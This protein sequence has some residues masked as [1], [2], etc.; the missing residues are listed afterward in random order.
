M[1]RGWGPRGGRAPPEG[2]NPKRQ[3]IHPSI[4]KPD[5][6]SFRGWADRL[7]TSETLA[8]LERTIEAQ[9]PS[10]SVALV[11]SYHHEDTGEIISSW[12]RT[13]P[14]I[15]PPGWK[16][17]SAKSMVPADVIRSTVEQRVP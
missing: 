13:S 4:A 5:Y 15:P 12:Y 11:R 14:A 8:D 6:A 9:D 10:R 2:A 3:I 1:S 17:L 16:L 7:S